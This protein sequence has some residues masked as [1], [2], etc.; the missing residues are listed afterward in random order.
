MVLVRSVSYPT[1]SARAA[2]WMGH[3]SISRTFLTGLRGETWG[4]RFLRCDGCGE[5]G[6]REYGDVVFL[7]ER[8]GSMGDL[9]RSLR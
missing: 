2:E 4:T 5:G 7:T 9:L 8:L 1:H 6:E 3:T